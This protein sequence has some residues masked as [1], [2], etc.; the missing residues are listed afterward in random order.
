MIAN[1][2][3]RGVEYQVSGWLWAA[4]GASNGTIVRRDDGRKIRGAKMH[5]GMIQTGISRSLERAAERALETE[6][7]REGK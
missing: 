5:P 1:F 2:S 3:Y 6:R 4:D 7:A